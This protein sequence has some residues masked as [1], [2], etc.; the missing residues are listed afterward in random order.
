MEV[1]RTLLSVGVSLKAIT[2]KGLTPLPYAAQ[3]SQLDL[4]KYLV[5]K[6][7]NVRATTKAGVY[8]ACVSDSVFLYL[9]PLQCHF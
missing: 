1:V 4:V 9:R 7:A 6:G 5:K 8:G 2:R 3:G